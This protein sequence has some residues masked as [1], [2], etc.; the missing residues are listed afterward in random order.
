MPSAW[1]RIPIIA[2]YRNTAEGLKI[3]IDPFWIPPDAKGMEKYEG[4]EPV[5]EIAEEPIEEPEPEEPVFTQPTAPVP[6][7][8]ILDQ[9]AQTRPDQTTLMPQDH[10]YEID[11]VDW[12]K[13]LVLADV[14]HEIPTAT[15]GTWDESYTD[16]TEL[17]TLFASVDSDSSF[18]IDNPTKA[19]ESAPKYWL[20]D[21]GEADT[22]WH[23]R[24]VD[25]GGNYPFIPNDGSSQQ[26]RYSAVGILQWT[27]PTYTKTG[28]G[29]GNPYYNNT[30]LK[31]RAI[32]SSLVHGI[33]FL[34]R[35]DNDSRK[36]GGLLESVAL[37]YK[38]CG[39]IMTAK[40]ASAFEIMIEE[41]LD[42]LAVQ[43][44]NLPNTNMS[45]KGLIAAADVA[46]DP[47]FTSN[48]NIQTKA[49][50]AAKNL[51][52][53]KTDGAYN[54]YSDSNKA[55]SNVGIVMEGRGR[56]MSYGGRSWS[57]IIS[58][59]LVT[60]GMAT[61]DFLNE[62][63]TRY[64]KY[65]VYQ[66]FSPGNTGDEPIASDVHST[67]VPGVT[68]WQD[69]PWARYNAP[70]L[71]SVNGP[72]MA[73]N[74]NGNRLVATNLAAF[75]ADTL[76]KIGSGVPIGSV[77]VQPTALDYSNFSWPI[78]LSH[79]V[80]A[81]DA[82][83][84]ITSRVD[85]AEAQR[86]PSHADYTNNYNEAFPNDTDDG[87]GWNRET[88]AHA[89]RVNAAD[90]NNDIAYFISFA[91]YKGSNSGYGGGGR[92]HCIAKNSGRFGPILMSFR[93]SKAQKLGAPFLDLWRINDVWGKDDNGKK[94]SWGRVVGAINAGSASRT[95]TYNHIT[96][97]ATVDTPWETVFGVSKTKD[98]AEAADCI[99][100]YAVSYKATFSELANGLRLQCD[101]VINSGTDTVTELWMKLP[102]YEGLISKI[103]PTVNDFSNVNKWNAPGDGWTFNTVAERAEC[104][105]TQVAV[106]VIST[107][108]SDITAPVN[109]RSEFEIINYVQGTVTP[110]CGTT[111]GTARSANGTY[112]EV[113]NYASGSPDMWLEASADFIG[114]INTAKWSNIDSLPDTF[115]VQ[116]WT[117][118]AWA[119]LGETLQST[120]QIRIEKDW[121]AGSVYAY[122]TLGS[123]R[124]VRLRPTESGIDENQI[125]YLDIDLHGNIGTAITFPTTT[126]QE[127]FDIE[128][129]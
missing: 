84:I 43:D 125:H 26:S 29:E 121:G 94:F 54:D 30:P 39:D 53:D 69:E 17:V 95:V 64:H 67:R 70:Y 6:Q 101:F 68:N 117:G 35:G 110:G 114:D 65:Y 1:K 55:W 113:I 107:D 2:K 49:I 75:V 19:A 127:T 73:Y 118:S 48:T 71:D 89:V 60:Y 124:S 25:L 82:I 116:Y 15:W 90:A 83:S 51:L 72:F 102:V 123:S 115:D 50:A 16:V 32:V 59:R 96:G 10:Q 79:M 44:A 111:Y 66:L 103:K 128:T 8:F 109:L 76:A 99:G 88:Q 108:A 14:D 61:W 57:D 62:L 104:D 87:I 56:E 41:L 7:E 34:S 86:F 12:M 37:T 21:A 63:V 47:N 46:G 106:S 38:H 92:I 129:S 52:F 126:A 100:D 33:L 36:T 91:G 93:E 74:S 5:I 58:A 78:H 122:I 23:R 81:N 98:N 77:D 20:Y 18:G 27:I 11:A 97:L 22:G 40:V 31:N 120:S 42:R 45:M 4:A 28:G 80:P 119:S 3:E 85:T 13:G 24:W 105:G 112:T 9:G